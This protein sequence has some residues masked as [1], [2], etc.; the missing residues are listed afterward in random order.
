MEIKLLE[1]SI[2]SYIK[3]SSNLNKVPA[4]IYFEWERILMDKLTERYNATMAE[5]SGRQ[6]RNRKLDEEAKRFGSCKRNMQYS[7]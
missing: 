3:K 6:A 7:Q 4:P 2:K 1:A 5:H